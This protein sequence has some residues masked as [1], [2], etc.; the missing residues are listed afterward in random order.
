MALTISL[1]FFAGIIVVI[2][3]RTGNLRLWP[4]AATLFGFSPAST[5]IAPAINGAI[6]G[7][8]G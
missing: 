1:A 4:L 6:S 7:I 2:L 8:A 3:V 5:G